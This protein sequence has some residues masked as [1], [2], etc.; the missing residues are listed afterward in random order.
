MDSQSGGH[1][2]HGYSV[3]RASLDDHRDHTVPVGVV[4]WQ[5]T[6]P[7]YGWRWLEHDEEVCGVDPA[8]RRLMRI[9]KD[10]IQRWVNARKVP[11]EPAPVEPTSDRFSPKSPSC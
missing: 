7:W 4:A 9:T 3:V 5:T 11:Y 8:T 1:I 6:K 10:Q 2:Q